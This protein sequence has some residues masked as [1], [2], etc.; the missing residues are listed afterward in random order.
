VLLKNGAVVQQVYPI[1]WQT[2]IGNPNLKTAEKDKIKLQFPGKPK[3]FYLNK[4]REI[5]KQR[6]LDWVKK[7]YDIELESD[8]VGDA[9]GIAFYCLDHL[10]KDK[11]G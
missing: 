4:S 2:Y 9:F 1:S 5:R 10:S 7:V 3:S 8:D 11:N 6:T